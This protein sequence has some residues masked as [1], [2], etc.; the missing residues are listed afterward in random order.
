MARKPID[1][2]RTWLAKAVLWGFRGAKWG[3]I[4]GGASGA[5]AGARST[6]SGGEEF[7]WGLA[8]GCFGGAVAFAAIPALAS[9]WFLLLH[10]VSQLSGAARVPV[11]RDDESADD[12]SADDEPVRPA[13][14]ASSPGPTRTRP[15]P[16]GT[17]QASEKV[18]PDCGETVKAAARICRFCRF[19]FAP[20]EES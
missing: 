10:M 1:D 18:C 9:V 14:R 16:R 15:A 11:D 2:A 6:G 8:G 7:G 17:T 5:I 3:L 19:E 4:L 13:P 20:E 12:E